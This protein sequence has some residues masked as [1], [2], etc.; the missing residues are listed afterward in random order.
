MPTSLCCLNKS[1]WKDIVLK[2]VRGGGFI[3]KLEV[4]QEL[5]HIDMVTIYAYVTKFEMRLIED[6][7]LKWERQMILYRFISLVILIQNVWNIE[8]VFVFLKI[9]QEFLS[10]K[11]YRNF[12]FPCLPLLFKIVL[13]FLAK[14]IKQE[15][16]IKAI[17][18]GK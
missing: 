18:N 13:E 7:V 5:L 12:F 16:E 1:K 3:I 10:T 6:T 15:T 4:L 17:H 14:R 8:S 11:Y 2:C 9:L